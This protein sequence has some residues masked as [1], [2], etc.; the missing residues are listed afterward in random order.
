M[1][2]TFLVHFMLNTLPTQYG[3]FKI[4]YNTY[5]DKGSINELMAMCVQQDGQLPMETRQSEFMTNQGKKTNQAKKRSKRNIPHEIDIKREA[6][7]LC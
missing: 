6:K 3:L 4:F 7:C 1:S 2:Q 5:K